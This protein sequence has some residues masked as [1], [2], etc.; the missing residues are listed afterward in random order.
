MVRRRS[1]PEKSAANGCQMRQALTTL[2]LLC[3]RSGSW[4]PWRT[5]AS[6]SAGNPPTANIHRHP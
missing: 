6:K 4:T 3:Q 1:S 2:S 5:H